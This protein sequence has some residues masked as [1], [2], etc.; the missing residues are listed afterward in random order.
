MDLNHGALVSEATALPTEPQPL[1]HYFYRLS[2]NKMEQL[3][4]KTHLSQF[5]LQVVTLAVSPGLV[6]KEETHYK[7]ALSS[8]PSAGY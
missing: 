1:P 3:D 6:V 7:E 2:W 8:N 4:L 5:K